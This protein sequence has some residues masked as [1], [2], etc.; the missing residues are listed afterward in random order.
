MSTPLPWDAPLGLGEPPSPSRLWHEEA[1]ESEIPSICA[2]SHT[3]FTAAASS[4]GV[5]AIALL[6]GPPDSAGLE[7]L[8]S[9]SLTC[10]Q[11]LTIWLGSIIFLII[12]CHHDIA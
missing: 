7:G 4:A 5:M 1:W 12:F 11:G 2:G 8:H 10:S 3:L 9:T 6:A